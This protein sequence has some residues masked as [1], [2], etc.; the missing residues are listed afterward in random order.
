MSELLFLSKISNLKSDIMS[1]L[2]FLS[3]ISNLKSTIYVLSYAAFEGDL[4]QFLSFYRKLHGKLVHY[5]L[6]K[7]VYD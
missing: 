2:L 6:G 3:K 5:F 7:A 1:E 4:Q